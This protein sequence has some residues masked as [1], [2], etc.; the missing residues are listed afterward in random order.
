MFFDYLNESNALMKNNANMFRDYTSK[1][2]RGNES[3]VLSKMYLYFYVS[4]IEHEWSV[5]LIITR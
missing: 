2:F 5:F 4:S 1:C 3:K